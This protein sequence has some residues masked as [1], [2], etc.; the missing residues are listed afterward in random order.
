MLGL[1]A[2]AQ[3]AIVP[4]WLGVCLVVGFPRTISKSK[5]TKHLLSF[6]LT[7]VIIVTSLAT[8]IVTG[9]ASRNLQNVE[10]DKS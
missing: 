2:T 8:Y 6:A 4:V 1:A 3:I 7:V 10:S 5:I 9:A